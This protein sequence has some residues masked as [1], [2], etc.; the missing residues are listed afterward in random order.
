MRKDAQNHLL[1]SVSFRTSSNFQN[2]RQ[3]K[4]GMSILLSLL[5]ECFIRT[6]WAAVRNIHKHEH[7]LF[8]SENCNKLCVWKILS[9]LMAFQKAYWNQEKEKNMRLKFLVNESLVWTIKRFENLIAFQLKIHSKLS[10]L[11]SAIV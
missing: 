10:L 8:Q 6:P 9:F 3:I 7:D 2:A 11:W 5:F 4:R 1:D